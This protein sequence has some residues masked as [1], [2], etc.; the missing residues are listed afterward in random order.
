[1]S[2]YYQE[3]LLPYETDYFQSWCN[4]NGVDDERFEQLQFSPFLIAVLKKEIRQKEAILRDDII[5]SLPLQESSRVE[6]VGLKPEFWGTRQKIFEAPKGMAYS[7]TVQRE[8]DA[9]YVSA[10]GFELQP[11]KAQTE[12]L[13]GEYLKIDTY[14]KNGKQFGKITVKQRPEVTA[15]PVYNNGDPRIPGNILILPSRF[16]PEQDGAAIV[17][18]RFDDW[19]VVYTETPS[20]TGFHDKTDVTLVPF[21]QEK[22]RK[23]YI[24]DFGNYND[25]ALDDFIFANEQ[26]FKLP[27][28]VTYDRFETRDFQYQYRPLNALILPPI[29]RDHWEDLWDNHRILIRL[30][31]T[32]KPFDNDS[33]FYYLNFDNPRTLYRDIRK[34]NSFAEKDIFLMRALVV[35]YGVAKVSLRET[36]RV[37]LSNDLLDEK[38][39][40][41]LKL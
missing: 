33:R 4:Q 30:H 31:P 41:K 39:H 17:F 32:G 40:E 38:E 1:M 5:K 23:L 34:F 6:E 21:K 11:L 16:D 3:P 13:V 37:A 14:T 15:A 24:P 22:D 8:T 29:S 12:V 27:S 10:E 20:L 36:L 9:G 35:R 26:K 25:F 7:M 2:E 19:E 28:T 18:A